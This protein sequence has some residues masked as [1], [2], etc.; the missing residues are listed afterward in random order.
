MGV[1][2][3]DRLYRSHEGCCH[4]HRETKTGFQGGWRHVDKHAIGDGLRAGV[5]KDDL[6][7]KALGATAAVLHAGGL[8]RS[9]ASVSEAKRNKSTRTRLRGVGGLCRIRFT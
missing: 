6:S 4:R 7:E 9:R 3:R 5:T 8:A 1:L 2:L